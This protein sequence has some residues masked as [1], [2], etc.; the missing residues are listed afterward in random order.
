M[1]TKTAIIPGPF[2]CPEGSKPKTYKVT[3]TTVVPMTHTD[4]SLWD[5]GALL[6]TIE[7]SH[8]SEVVAVEMTEVTA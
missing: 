5:F 8:W 4:P 6:E 2:A 1:K 7:A 3:I